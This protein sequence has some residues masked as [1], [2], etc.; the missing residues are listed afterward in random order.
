MN[1]V[2]REFLGTEIKEGDSQ[3]SMFS[4]ARNDRTESRGDI[5]E[6]LK[7]RAVL[8]GDNLDPK[9]F[10]YK[11]D[12]GVKAKSTHDRNNARAMLAAAPLMIAQQG[13]LK[14]RK[15]MMEGDTSI[16]TDLRL[17]ETTT[18]AQVFDKLKAL[19]PLAILKLCNKE[20]GDLVKE[21]LLQQSDDL[22]FVQDVLDLVG[23]DSAL[24][25]T[26]HAVL[27][28]FARRN[29]HRRFK[30]GQT[31]IAMDRLRFTHLASPNDKDE[32][33]IRNINYR[34]KRGISKA[35]CHHFQKR[36]GCR[37][38]YVCVFEHK[39]IICESKSHGAFSCKDRSQESAGFN[40]GHKKRFREKRK[41]GNSVPL[42]S[43]RQRSR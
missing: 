38:L 10:N 21:C 23:S 20:V 6:V 41:R 1:Q 27:A 25:P 7:R 15:I 42:S 31:S 11:S 29:N 33:N 16:L 35:I 26:L 4:I 8:Y 19:P 30:H 36:T 28:G 5:E 17:D 43:R 9:W 3:G 34:N 2:S 40:G 12:L 14:L 22:D 32:P 37:K 18:V 24:T 13:A 39:C